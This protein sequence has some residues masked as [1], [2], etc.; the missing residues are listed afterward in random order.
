MVN[1]LSLS[2][3]MVWCL[4]LF[5]YFVSFPMLGLVSDSSTTRDSPEGLKFKLFGPLGEFLVQ[6]KDNIFFD[7]GGKDLRVFD[8]G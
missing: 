7:N 6:N 2:I 8:F 3:I 1:F 5:S 4:N